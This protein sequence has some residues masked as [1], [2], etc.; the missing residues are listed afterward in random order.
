MNDGQS[1]RQSTRNSHTKQTD[2]PF[3]KT[4]RLSGAASER[5]PMRHRVN[6]STKNMAMPGPINVCWNIEG[7]ATRAEPICEQARV[8]AANTI[9]ISPVA[10]RGSSRSIQEGFGSPLKLHSSLGVSKAGRLDLRM[11]MRMSGW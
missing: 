4:V 11:R 3:I 8:I 7:I 5:Q 2:T 9:D 1:V 6:P 10:S